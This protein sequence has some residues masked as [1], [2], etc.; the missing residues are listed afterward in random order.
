[1]A[2]CHSLAASG[3][4]PFGEFGLEVNSATRSTSWGGRSDHAEGLERR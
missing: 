4:L 2:F 1:M 3:S